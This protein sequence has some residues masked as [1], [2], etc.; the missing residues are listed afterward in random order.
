MSATI[1]PTK[2]G[3]KAMIVD[4]EGGHCEVPPLADLKAF[5]EWIL[6]DEAPE[7]GRFCYLAGTLYVDLSME[8]LFTHNQVKSAVTVKLTSIVESDQLG[9][10]FPDGVRLS[11]LGVDLSTEPDA[12]FASFESFR[13]LRIRPD[14]GKHE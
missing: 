12:L 6:S 14:E 1:T 11:H 13:D 8:Q 3:L 2:T 4:V 7:R 9:Y 5:R 10:L